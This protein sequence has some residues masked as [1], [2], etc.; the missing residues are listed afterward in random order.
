MTIRDIQ[1]AQK[2]REERLEPNRDFVLGVLIFVDSVDLD[3][4]V[5]GRPDYV[6]VSE[7]NQPQSSFAVLNRAVPPL[8]GLQVK[9]GWPEKPPFERQ[10]LGVWDGIADLSGYTEDDGGVFNSSPH[11]QSHQ[12]PSESS[13]GTDP[14]LIY[15]PALQMLKTTGDGATLIVDVAE[16]PS[17]RYQNDVRAFAGATLDLTASVPS[18]SGFI[19]YTLVYLDGITN[20]LQYV[21]GTA[22]PEAGPMPIPKP[23]LPTGGI[24]SA[25]V[26]L[27]NGQSAVTTSSHVEDTREFLEPRGNNTLD[28]ATEV[29]QVMYSVDGIVFSVQLPLT[30]GYGWMVNDDG[31]LLV[32]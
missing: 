2:E 24:A 9:I 4:K 14:V 3:A 16:L 7:F 8:V 13:P 15:Q 19:R 20:T 18:T 28:G 30:N 10:I 23:A 6:W 31:I 22:V 29:G 26:K 12:Y 27:S 32:V 5:N 17:F 1:I 25:Y 11:A 21:D